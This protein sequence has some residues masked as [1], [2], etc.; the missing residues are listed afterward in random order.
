ML[1][2]KR[3]CLRSQIEACLDPELVHFRSGRRSHAVKFSDRQVFNERRSHL[4]RDDKEAV[5]LSVIGRELCQELVVGDSRRCCQANSEHVRATLRG[6]RRTVGAAP[7]HK[8][9][10]LAEHACAMAL[11]APEGLKGTRD[12][13]LLLLGLVGAELAIAKPETMKAAGRSFS[14]VRFVITDLGR[15]TLGAQQRAW[16][17]DCQDCGTVMPASL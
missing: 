16:W 15:A 17:P 8:A 3:E 5:G 12:R 2:K 9:P 11:S 14:V 13:A 7:V 6:I 10:I 4:R 1:L